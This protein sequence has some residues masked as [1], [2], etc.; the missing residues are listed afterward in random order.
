M[1]RDLSG[2]SERKY[3]EPETSK[4]DYIALIRAMERRAGGQAEENK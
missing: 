4:C 2:H 1:E 3:E